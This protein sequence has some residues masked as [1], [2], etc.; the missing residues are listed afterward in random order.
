[1]AIDEW[2]NLKK[3]EK[4]KGGERKRVFFT[5]KKARNIVNKYEAL[6][7]RPLSNFSVKHQLI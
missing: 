3:N 6:N 2:L 5:V 7:V 1:M 4:H